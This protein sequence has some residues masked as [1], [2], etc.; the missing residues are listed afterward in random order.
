MEGR[1]KDDVADLD[2][3]RAFVAA[4]Q[5]RGATLAIAS[6]GR[7]EVIRAYMDL[8]A[9]GAFSDADI[10]T[11]A[12]LGSDYEDGMSVENGK[13][14]MLQLL[15]KRN[16]VTNLKGAAGVLF[17]DDDPANVDECRG[18]AFCAALHAAGL[19][20]RGARG[21]ERRHNEAAMRRWL[22][23]KQNYDST[24]PIARPTRRRPRRAASCAASR[25]LCFAFAIATLVPASRSIG[26]VVLPVADR[27]RV[28][29]G[30]AQRSSSAAAAVAFDAPVGTSM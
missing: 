26:Y 17:F 29:P 23:L 9:P 30:E 12:S 28:R 14:M 2:T 16:P 20:A 22:N 5:Q 19:H 3:F 1:W 25:T 8:I 15:C 6:F 7:S 13:P 18:S 27:Q 21:A 4:A 10:V 24:S 11:P